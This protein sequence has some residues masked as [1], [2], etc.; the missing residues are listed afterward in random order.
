ME[1]TISQALLAKS[2]TM[3][4]GNQL[5]S[6]MMSDD[7]DGFTKLLIWLT[8]FSI[9]AEVFFLILPYFIKVRIAAFDKH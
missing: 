9:V 8:L 1:D 4:L 2:E 6:S 3:R 5:A 7:L